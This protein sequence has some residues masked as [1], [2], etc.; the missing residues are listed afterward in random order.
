[1]AANY[2]TKHTN[3]CTFESLGKNI[4]QWL[5]VIVKM[6]RRKSIHIYVFIFRLVHQHIQEETLNAFLYTLKQGESSQIC[7]V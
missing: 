2:S 3:L 4:A 7:F 5:P 6:T 1:V